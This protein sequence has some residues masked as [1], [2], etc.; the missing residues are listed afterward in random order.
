MKVQYISSTF[1]QGLA[2]E[3]EDLITYTARVSSP[4]N[5]ENFGTAPQLLKYLIEHKHWSPFEMA[6]LT[7]EIETSRAIAAQILRH[8]SFS[9]Q[10]FSQRY[11]EANMGFETYPARRQDKKN[12]Q[13]SIDDLPPNVQGFWRDA[14]KMTQKFCEEWY[15][16][17]LDE[18]IA[19]ELA[20][21]LLPMSVTTRIYMKG[22]VRSW[23]H[24]LQVRDADGVQQEHREI[25][26]EIKNIFCLMYPHTSEALGWR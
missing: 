10:E 13:N 20:R 3:P 4:K 22:S 2:E 1:G 12:R 15:Q 25:A 8:R 26:Q 7:V 23:I 21:M 14:Q 11:A 6:D 16:N 24:Y 9:F 19:K 5:Q 17:A 18:G